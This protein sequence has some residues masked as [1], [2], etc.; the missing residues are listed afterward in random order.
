MGVGGQGGGWGGRGGSVS[1][2]RSKGSVLLEA[3]LWEFHQDGALYKLEASPGPLSL[4]R[5]WGHPSLY[6]DGAESIEFSLTM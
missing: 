6:T 5:R 2:S 4:G 1:A 3:S